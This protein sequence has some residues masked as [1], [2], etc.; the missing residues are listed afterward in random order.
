MTRYTPTHPPHSISSL[1]QS[2]VEWPFGLSSGYVMKCSQLL[3]TTQF[4]HIYIYLYLYGCIHMCIVTYIWIYINDVTRSWQC[5]LYINISSLEEVYFPRVLCHGTNS[6]GI[7]ITCMCGWGLGSNL[8]LKALHPIQTIT[9]HQSNMFQ[10]L[11]TTN[12]IGLEFVYMIY[13][14]PTTISHLEYQ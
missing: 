3:Y 9:D 4:I 8:V 7:R 10:P 5:R 13:G 12:R 6:S 1:S 2:W 11:F 14:T